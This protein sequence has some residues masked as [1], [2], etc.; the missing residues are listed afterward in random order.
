MSGTLSFDNLPWRSTDKNEFREEFRA[1]NRGQ[2]S[3]HSGDRVTNI[4]AAIDTKG[5]KYVKQIINV[6]I[7]GSVLSEIKVI[8]INTTGTDKV[9]QN[10][11]IMVEIRKNALPC[12][13][14]SAKSVSKHENS[15]AG[16]HYTDMESF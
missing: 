4:G 1:A 12:G 9:I 15:I 14:I 10:D 6:G 11:A 3:N 16:T 2:D 5:V 13:L 7:K 8:R